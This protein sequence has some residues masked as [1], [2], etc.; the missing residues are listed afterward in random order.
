MRVGILAAVC[1]LVV[2]CS[3][4]GSTGTGGGAVGCAKDSDCKDERICVNGAC[5]SP[6][7]GTGTPPGATPGGTTPTGTSGGGHPPKC[8]A[9]GETCVCA[10]DG[11][12]YDSSDLKE[13]AS[14]TG[15]QC[16]GDAEWPAK[17]ACYCHQTVCTI[18]VFGDTCICS[19]AEPDQGDKVVP[20]CSGKIC[21]ISK[22]DIAPMCSCFKDLTQCPDAG[23]VPVA[24]C[25]TSN[26]TCAGK[27]MASCN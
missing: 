10:V 21:C 8:G 17:G 23:D 19:A 14:C 5:V 24:S 25:T 22:S 2:A 6:G 4:S 7:G 1:A 16:C 18:S 11:P 13:G 3:S 15:A 27:S 20:S 9:S 12:Y 26:M